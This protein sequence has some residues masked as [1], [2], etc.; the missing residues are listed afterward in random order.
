MNPPF[1]E[2]AQQRLDIAEMPIPADE[3]QAATLRMRLVDQLWKN[4]ALH[5]LKIDRA[6][7]TVCRHRFLPQS[8]LEEAYADTAIPTHWEHGV[9]VSSA[10]QPSVVV[11]MLEQLRLELGMRVLEIGAGTGYNAALLAELVGPSG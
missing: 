4:G 7:R 6:M 10:S 11:I 8:P 1:D 9:A 3:Q 5:N 2:H